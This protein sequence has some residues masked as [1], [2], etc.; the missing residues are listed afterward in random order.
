MKKLYIIYLISI[1]LIIGFKGFS[2]TQR[3]PLSEK[4]IIKDSI[5]NVYPYEKWFAMIS[6]GTYK[7]Q[8]K[9][10]SIDEYILLKIEK[11]SSEVNKEIYGNKSPNFL[12]NQIKFSRMTDL[13]GEK[14][15]D[16][17]LKDKIVVLNFWFVQCA[18]CKMEIPDLNKLYRKYKETDKI[19]FLSVC[20]DAEPNI[21]GFL[22][23]MPF[24]YKIIPWGE[25][26]AYDFKVASYP[27]NLVIEKGVVKFCKAGYS[28]KNVMDLENTI[29]S[30]IAKN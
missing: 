8:K 21:I 23:T 25:D 19:V 27:T 14:Y 15:D 28:P 5:G 2:Q 18:P 30:L 12:G 29:E 1:L 24:F 13:D 11:L 9:K 22:R 6:T 26:V 16:K 4:S 20:L 7:V 3:I 17:S 10:D